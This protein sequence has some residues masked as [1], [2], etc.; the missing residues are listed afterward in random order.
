MTKYHSCTNCDLKFE[1]KNK[2]RLKSAFGF[3]Y[4]PWPFVSPSK[5]LEDYSKV[6]CPRCKHIE[7]N[8][9]LR[10]FGVFKPKFFAILFISLILLMLIAD[11]AGWWPAR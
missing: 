6:S 2:H 11:V 1:I 10:V 5:S 7:I 8:D 9:E 3:Q 4:L